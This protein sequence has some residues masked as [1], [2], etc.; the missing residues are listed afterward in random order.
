MNTIFRYKPVP[1][2]RSRMNLQW[3]LSQKTP[4]VWLERF[5]PC[6]HHRQS[7]EIGRLALG[8]VLER[9]SSTVNLKRVV[10]VTG[11]VI[12]Q[13]VFYGSREEKTTDDIWKCHGENHEVRKINY[14]I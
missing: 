5:A 10:L 7:R 1:E 8:G 3:R 13:F 4:K 14:I 6:F 12:I 9:T 2:A 11:P